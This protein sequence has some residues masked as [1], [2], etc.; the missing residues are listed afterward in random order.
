[1]SNDNH[2]SVTTWIGW[3]KAGDHVAAQRVWERYY[4]RLVRLARARLS[5]RATRSAAAD[6]EDAAISA[7]D[8]FCDGAKRGRFPKLGGREDLWRL[9]VVITARKVADQFRNEGRQKRGGG[10]VVGESAIPRDDAE[11][12]C[13]DQIIGREPTPEFAAT[14]ADELRHLLSGL[15]DPTLR[16][17][18]L[19]RLEGFTSD[20][21][22][23]RLGCARRTVGYKLE[24]IRNAWTGK[25]AP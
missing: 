17:I 14:M 1:M 12:G 13:L 23:V 18:A 11:S 5:S 15:S 2:G 6:E 24:Y 10:R 7:F 9:F 8:S 16:Q 19:W 21:I 25:G 22:A 20:E 4:G 3:I